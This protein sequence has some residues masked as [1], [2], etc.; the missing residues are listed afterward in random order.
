MTDYDV[1][2][3]GGGPAGATAARRIAQ[4]NLSVVVFDKE[5]FPR[6]KACA[7]GIRNYVAENLDFSIQ[8]VVERE[9]YGQRLYGPSG[10]LVDCRRSYVSGQMV[11]RTE[12]DN[13]LLQKAGEAGAE[14]RDSVKIVNVEQNQEMVIVETEDGQKI[15]SKYLIGADGINSTVAKSLGF[16]QGWTDDSAAIAIEVEAEVGKETVERICGV[17]YDKEGVAIDI[18]FGPVPHGYAWCFPKRSIL[19]IGAGCRQDLG[20]DLRVHFNKWFDEFKQKHDISP[21]I[22]SDTAARLPYSGAVKKTVIGRTIII[23][24]TAGF[25]SPYSGEGIPMAITS[26][27]IAA[28]VIEKAMKEADPRMLKE[29]EKGWKSEFG[30]DLK[31]AKSLAKMVFKSEKNMETIMQIAH[32]DEHVN[33]IMYKMI[34]GEDTYKN[35]KKALT[36]RIMLKH[37]KAGISLYI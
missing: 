20:K 14:V 28:P 8:E 13:L 29:Y 9:V 21:T 12:F 5:T 25:V 2:V 32:K 4:R 16:Y 34:A 1:I 36:K 26:G 30:D 23:G 35:L 37:P 31:V 19:S 7:G 11:M 24:D 15:S 22:L 18:F 33:E 3:V 27:I 10:V 17:P 6:N